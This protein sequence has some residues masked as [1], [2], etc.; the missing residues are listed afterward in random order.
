M[1]EI[2]LK[3]ILNYKSLKKSHSDY[4]YG[5]WYMITNIN[6]NKSYVGKSIEYMFRLKQ[7]LKI[8]HKLS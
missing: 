1:K 3:E 4:T 8:Q 7:H 6:N 5:G 2:N